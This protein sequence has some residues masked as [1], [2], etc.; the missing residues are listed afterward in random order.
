MVNVP[1]LNP[2]STKREYFWMWM[3][4]LVE[5]LAKHMIS[6][7]DTVITECLQFLDHCE[8]YGRDVKTVI[9]APL[10]SEHIHQGHSWAPKPLVP[11]VPLIQRTMVVTLCAEY[12]CFNRFTFKITASKKST[13]LKKTPTSR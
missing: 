9:E 11:F 8:I 7:R 6:V 2:S 12:Q 3:L 5:N 10:A 13:D 1:L 4:S